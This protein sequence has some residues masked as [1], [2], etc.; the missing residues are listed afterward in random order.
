MTLPEEGAAPKSPPAHWH[1]EFAMRVLVAVTIALVL[2][3][4]VLL[5][6]RASSIV[7]IAFAGA[8][9]AVG[10][11]GVA[12]NVGRRMRLS[13]RAA[14]LVEVLVLL[15]LSVVSVRLLAPR[16]ADQVDELIRVLPRSLARLERWLDDYQWGRSTLGGLDAS[17]VLR[18]G[19]RVL[20]RATSVLSQVIA[21]TGVMLLVF[22]IGVYAASTPGLYVRGVLR[23]FPKGRRDRAREVIDAV[24]HTL[25]WWLLGR[26][27][28]MAAIGLMSGVGLWL[29]GV[30]LALVLG[31]I[32]GLS[33]FIPNIGFFLAGM[34][35]LLFAAAQGMDTV[36]RA[37]AVY[38]V[39]QGIEGYLITPLVEHRAV[40]V[41]PALN[42]VAQLLMAVLFGFLGLILA[43]PL[44]AVSFV[45]VRIVYVEGILQDRPVHDGERG[46]KESRHR[47]DGRRRWRMG[48]HPRR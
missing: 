38:L 8:L 13:A 25:R 17:G 41:P 23:L 45:V 20:W 43:A 21:G 7:L 16:I 32:A 31:F 2:G 36:L 5:L 6:W 40:H 26:T 4:A 18:Q 46:D 3:S 42:I 24:G 44:V 29:L 12:D 48:A 30:P 22:V 19:A 14:L 37:G 1:G 15:F 10:L 28:A 47:R 35:I 39:V 11:H 34:L 9:V 33:S 27:V